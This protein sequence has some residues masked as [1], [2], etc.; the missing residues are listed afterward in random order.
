MIEEA[1]LLD[2]KI[3]CLLA[4]HF[5]P[6]SVPDDGHHNGYF[7]DTPTWE[8]VKIA[9]C[10]CKKCRGAGRLDVWRDSG[11]LYQEP[12]FPDATYA[13]G[14]VITCPACKGKGYDKEKLAELTGEKVEP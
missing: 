3:L 6:D 12:Q 5:H 9:A 13:A 8:K 4:G 10:P 2:Y 14:S 11:K 1:R 7:I